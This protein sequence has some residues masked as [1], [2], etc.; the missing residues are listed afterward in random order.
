MSLLPTCRG[1]GLVVW[2]QLSCKGCWELQPCHVSDRGGG[3]VS[4]T[5][6]HMAEAEKERVSESPSHS[7]LPSL[8]VRSPTWLLGPTQEGQTPTTHSAKALDKG[9]FFGQSAQASARTQTNSGVLAKSPG[10]GCSGEP[11][12]FVVGPLS[13]NP[14]PPPALPLRGLVPT[15]QAPQT[16]RQ[17]VPCPW[18]GVRGQGGSSTVSAGLPAWSLS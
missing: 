6:T 18:P 13:S 16:P 17:Q 9:P 14:C 11:M 8:Q 15:G 10:T 4:P 3:L 1:P 2:P 12:V 5:A 7:Q